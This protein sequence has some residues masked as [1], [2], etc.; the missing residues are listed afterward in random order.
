MLLRG[1]TLQGGLGHN[2]AHQTQGVDGHLLIFGRGQIIRLDQ[3]RVLRPRAG[4]MDRSS[5][6]RTQIT[7]TYGDSSEGM[8]RLAEPVQRQGLDVELNIGPFL[9]G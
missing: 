7:D 4:Q 8:E 3:G 5:T 9:I 2:L 6:G 1:K